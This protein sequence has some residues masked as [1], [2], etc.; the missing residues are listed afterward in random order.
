MSV[1]KNCVDFYA[2]RTTTLVGGEDVVASST[3]RLVACAAVVAAGLLIVGVGAGRAFAAPG[4]AS[5]AGPHSAR[6]TSNA[7]DPKSHPHPRDS[8]KPDRPTSTVGN[9]RENVDVAPSTVQK[10]NTKPPPAATKFSGS[11]TIPIPRIPKRDELPA[12]GLPYLALFY[13]TVVIPVPTLADVFAALQPQ[14]KPTPTPVPALRAEDKLPAVVDSGGGGGGGADPLSAAATGEPQVLHA[15]IVMAP[16][17]VPLPAD[18]APITPL[19]M[20]SGAGPKQ[21]APAEGHT[22]RAEEATASAGANAPVIRGSLPPSEPPATTLLTPANGRSAQAGYSRYVPNPTSAELALV[23]LP[24]LAGLVL[25][26][27]GGG[28]IGYRQANSVR[29]LRA[30]GDARFLR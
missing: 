7:K 17:P 20:T 12:S 22:A 27:F 8:S 13:T 26:T 15:P 9:G 21:A 18:L 23:A 14:P 30:H 11:I 16:I 25:F 1:C 19:D 28:F 6:T 10:T 5:S 24:G 4:D 29:L 2:W 3:M